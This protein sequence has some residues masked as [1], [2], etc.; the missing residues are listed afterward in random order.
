VR[1]THAEVVGEQLGGGK[2]RC[3]NVDHRVGI[4]HRQEKK[5]KKSETK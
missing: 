1:R 2:K 4:L 5:E 3:A